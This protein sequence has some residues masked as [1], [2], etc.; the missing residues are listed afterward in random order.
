[1]WHSYH[2][3]YVKVIKGLQWV[4]GSLLF[5]CSISCMQED[6]LQFWPI[7]SWP[8]DSMVP[9]RLSAFLS[10]EK[11]TTLTLKS[12]QP[13]KSVTYIDPTWREKSYTPTLLCSFIYSSIKQSLMDVCV[14]PAHICHLQGL[15][16]LLSIISQSSLHFQRASLCQAQPSLLGP[17]AGNR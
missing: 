5:Q 12:P 11:I 16:A 15:Q 10:G 13:G 9:D 14:S 17:T 3:P 7:T 4:S 8:T 2:I 6:Q 1:M